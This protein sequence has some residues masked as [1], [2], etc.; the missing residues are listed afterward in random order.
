[1]NLSL[2]QLRLFEAIARQGHLTRAADE[3]AISQSAAS[4]ALRELESN[5]GYA[6]FHRLGRELVIT[7][8]GREALQKVI[9]I[10]TLAEGLRY[11]EGDEMCGPL[12]IA[13]SVTIAS[14]LLPALLSEFIARYPKVE[15]DICIT[16]TAEVIQQLESGQVHLGLIEGP[17]T[18]KQLSINP[19]QQDELA[20]F[21]NPSH[22]L[23]KNKKVTLRALQN[24]QWV[25]REHGSGT[26]KVFDTAIQKAGIQAK[27]TLE[28]NRQEAIKQ[29]VKAGLGIG[30]LS[31]LSI[32]NEVERG[33]LCRLNTPLELHR[34]LSVAC[35]SEPE[36][37]PL[38]N[39][40]WKFLLPS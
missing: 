36:R 7:D 27:I 15:P 37:H 20:I 1:M 28:L 23:A 14:Y 35:W 11:S 13:A 17:A 3:Q 18:H 32:V 19:W 21:C 16:N 2:R 6:L 10:L 24:Q 4:Q 31:A 9:Q 30:C 12:R 34:V 40:F 29:A 25:V 33:E 26:R 38:A 22:E 39:A 8:R 5:L